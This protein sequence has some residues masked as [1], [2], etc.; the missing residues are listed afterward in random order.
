MYWGTGRDSRYSGSR[1]GIGGIWGL[2]GGV[3]VMRGHQGL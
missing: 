3:W 1:R 2:L